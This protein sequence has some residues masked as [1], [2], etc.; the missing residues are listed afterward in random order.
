MCYSTSTSKEEERV[1]RVI[2]YGGG[3]WFGLEA[4]SGLITK[5]EKKIYYVFKIIVKQ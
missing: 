2:V 3:G 4:L 5:H 1:R